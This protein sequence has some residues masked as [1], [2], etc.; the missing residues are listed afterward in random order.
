MAST[1]SHARYA[2]IRSSASS[3]Q[4]AKRTTA[5]PAKPAESFS[6]IAPFPGC[7]RGTGRGLSK[8][9]TGSVIRYWDFL[10]NLSLFSSG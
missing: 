7:S 9:G 8:P 3:S 4:I 1:A 10:L 5:Q 2:A 6:L